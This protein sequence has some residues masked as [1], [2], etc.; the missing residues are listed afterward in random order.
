MKRLNNIITFIRELSWIVLY[1]VL[2]FVLTPFFYDY[3]SFFMDLFDSD[4]T[5]HA[6][7]NNFFLNALKMT[8]L[9]FILL[10]CYQFVNKL[11]F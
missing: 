8:I 9:L 11:I 2:V 1:Y 7:V 10:V 3:K 6:K 5:L 4:S